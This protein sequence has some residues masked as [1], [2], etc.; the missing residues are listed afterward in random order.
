MKHII[1]CPECE[2]MK[3]KLVEYV[4]KKDYNES[5]KK[6]AKACKQYHKEWLKRV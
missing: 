3:L 1:L 6:L 4:E 2:L 5:I